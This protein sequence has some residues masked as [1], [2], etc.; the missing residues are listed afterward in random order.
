MIQIQQLFK[1]CN[2][3]KTMNFYVGKETITINSHALFVYFYFK[4]YKPAQLV[5]NTFKYTA[6]DR[7][8]SRSSSVIAVRTNQINEIVQ[9]VK[10][11]QRRKGRRDS[12]M[13]YDM[14]AVWRLQ[15]SHS[16]LHISYTTYISL[17]T[18]IRSYEGKCISFSVTSLIACSL[19]LSVSSCFPT[20]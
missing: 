17:G 7:S 11:G 2:R 13:Q 15:Y 3:L 14:P 9:Y 6:T 4:H 12:H 16:S 10:E 8:Q 5:L 20:S 19:V 1:L 18:T